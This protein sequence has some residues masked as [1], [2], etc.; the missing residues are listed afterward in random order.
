MELTQNPCFK[1]ERRK[2][3]C[4]AT[5]SLYLDWKVVHEKELEERRKEQE[6][7]NVFLGYKAKQA[8]MKKKREHKE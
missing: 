2:M 5:C 7:R 3:G 4:H 8:R 1:C 6:I